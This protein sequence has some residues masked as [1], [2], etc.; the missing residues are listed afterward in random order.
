MQ[1][2]SVS[3]SKWNFRGVGFYRGRKT[4]EL[5]ENPSEQGTE[6]ITKSTSFT[7]AAMLFGCLAWT[8]IK[9]CIRVKWPSE[10]FLFA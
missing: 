4:G 10:D 2:S 9:T 7:I 3:R 8:K 1:E 5:G 6:G